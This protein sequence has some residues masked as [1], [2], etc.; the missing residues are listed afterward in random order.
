MDRS[1]R[2]IFTGVGRTASIQQCLKAKQSNTKQNEAKQMYFYLAHEYD[3][4]LCPTVYK[5]IYKNISMCVW[6]AD[7][8]AD[9]LHILVNA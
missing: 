1:S 2:S 8:A 4:V 9:I 3:S 6:L 5:Y 7:A